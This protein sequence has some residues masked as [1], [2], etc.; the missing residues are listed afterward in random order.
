MIIGIFVNSSISFFFYSLY[1]PCYDTSFYYVFLLSHSRIVLCILSSIPPFSSR[2]SIFPTKN[3]FFIYSQESCSCFCNRHIP[4]Q[5]LYLLFSCSFL[6][7][8]S[9]SHNSLLS[10]IN[11]LRFFLF[12]IIFFSFQLISAKLTSL[13]YPLVTLNTLLT[14]IPTRN[15]FFFLFF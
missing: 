7:Y 8:Y 12:F 3:S 4:K 10:I 5:N 1:Y 13:T 9:C 2:T 11:Y 14:F 15:P 6:F